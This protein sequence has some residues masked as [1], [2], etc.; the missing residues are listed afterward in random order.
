MSCPG[1]HC[2][3]CSAGSAAPALIL[4]A[5]Y[6]ADWLATHIVEVVVT[7]ATC[8]IL[9]FAA[10]TALIAWADRRDARHAASGP[11]LY[12]RADA[13][14]PSRTSQVSQ[15]TAPAIHNHYGPQFII[16]GT[17][18]QETAARLIRQALTGAVPDYQEIRP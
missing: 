1:L 5:C 17:D 9:T 7:S 3:C 6:G 14:P 13:L 4:A 10:V 16:N 15:G 12:V 18:G 8:G 11:L 2:A